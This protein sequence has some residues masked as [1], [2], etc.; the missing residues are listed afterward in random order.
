MVRSNWGQACDTWDPDLRAF[1]L[2]GKK[3][4]DYQGWADALC[5][6][7]RAPDYFEQVVNTIGSQEETRK[8]YKLYM[9]PGMSHFPGGRGV[10]D[11]ATLREP[12]FLA[13]QEWVEKGAEPG[14]IVGSR[15]AVAGRW[16][17]MTRPV[18]P[19]PEVARYRGTGSIDAAEN[20]TC[21]SPSP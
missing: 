20:F 4:I 9:I 11:R 15:P 6:P 13:L 16:G 14:A 2:K 5:W 10:F 1:G 18:C 17:A 3:F 7:S 8:F 12:L 21:G 19:Y